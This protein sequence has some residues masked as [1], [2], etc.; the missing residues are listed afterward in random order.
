MFVSL[1]RLCTT[2][3]KILLLNVTLH[4][5]VCFVVQNFILQGIF[6]LVMVWVHNHGGIRGNDVR[7]YVSFSPYVRPLL[8][9]DA[10]LVVYICRTRFSR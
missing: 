5:D 9:R 7:A 3:F 10:T 1:S 6:L 8:A 4:Y 2:K